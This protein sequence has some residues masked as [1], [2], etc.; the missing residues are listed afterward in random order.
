MIQIS[1]VSQSFGKKVVLDNITLQI[2]EGQ[3]VAL[4][5]SSG[6]GKSTLLRAILGTH[7]PKSGSIYVNN[8]LVNKPCRN[9]GTVYQHYSLYDFLTCVENVAFGPL[10]DQTN[11]WFRLFRP[12]AW[13]KLRK[14]H[15]QESRN[16][17]EEMELAH[18]CDLYPSE[19][20]GG[21]KQ[22]ASFAQALIMNPK[23][24]LLDEPF[25]A[26]DEA[27]RE[28]MQS[29]LLSL[30]EKNKHTESP[31]T[32][33][34]VTHELNEAIKVSDRIVG[35]LN[36]GQGAKVILDAYTPP[37]TLPKNEWDLAAESQKEVIRKMVLS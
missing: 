30:A 35:L 8:Q 4:I 27:I 17:L 11:P 21:M 13:R 26:L 2:P 31:I 7:L 14:Q 19:M 15:L 9:V 1:N 32:I 18:A 6:C 36:P 3:I 37:K 29:L 24:L 28:Q 10:M 12:F 34:I 22:R 16:I 23:V 25:G 20:S 33:L 5:G